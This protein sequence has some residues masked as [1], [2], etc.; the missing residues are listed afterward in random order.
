M[1]SAINIKN[2]SIFKVWN[3]LGMLASCDKYDYLIVQ[4]RQRNVYYSSQI[5]SRKRGHIYG[6]KWRVKRWINLVQDAQVF[7]LPLCSKPSLLQYKQI[8]EQK[9]Q[10]THNIT[11]SPYCKPVLLPRMQGW[12]RVPGLCPRIGSCSWGREASPG[13][14]MTGRIQRLTPTL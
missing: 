6:S 1:I 10:Q 7:R 13:T 3:F 4:D 2:W 12:S 11:I 14:S 8:W 5:W 9:Y